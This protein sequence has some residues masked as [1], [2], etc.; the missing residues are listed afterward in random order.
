M[1][2]NHHDHCG[3]GCDHNHDHDNASLNRYQIV[4]DQSQVSTDD[5]A[6]AADVQRI[7]A[8]HEQENHSPEIYQFL[9]NCV[10]LTTLATDDSERSVAQFVQ[11]VNEVIGDTT[12][13]EDKKLGYFFVKPMEEEVGGVKKK[14]ISAKRFLEKVIFYL[15]NDVFKDYGLDKIFTKDG[16]PVAFHQFFDSKTGAI[17]VMLLK[18]FIEN[19]RKIKE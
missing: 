19:L 2:H 4:I 7:L 3:C 6:I 15:W 14:V 9:L 8:A 12:H 11:R 16:K 17:N 13:S 10:D 5:A 18:E 1:E